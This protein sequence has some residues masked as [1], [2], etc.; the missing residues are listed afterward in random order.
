MGAPARAQIAGGGQLR[1][2]GAARH[3]RGGPAEDPVQNLP[4]QGGHGSQWVH[5]DDPQGLSEVDSPDASRDALIEQHRADGCLRAGA[6]PGGEVGKIWR[7][8]VRGSRVAGEQVRTEPG[9]ESKIGRAS[10]RERELNA[11]GEKTGKKSTY[12]RT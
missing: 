6:G 9:E 2:A 4:G 12:G 7:A 3:Q 1:S 11:V 8:G 5:A 10:C